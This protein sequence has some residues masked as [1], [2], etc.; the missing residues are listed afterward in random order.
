MEVWNWLE[1][2]KVRYAN[3]G[4]GLWAVCLKET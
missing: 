4:F 1:R 2:Q 3:D